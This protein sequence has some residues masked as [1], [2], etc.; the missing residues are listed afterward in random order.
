[1]L[2][3]SF[4]NFFL[5]SNFWA[6]F[7]TNLSIFYLFMDLYIICIF[8]GSVFFCVK[9]NWNIHSYIC[10]N[11]VPFFANINNATLNTFIYFFPFPLF[12]W[13][14]N[15]SFGLDGNL[16][17]VTQQVKGSAPNLTQVWFPNSCPQHL[18]FSQWPFVLLV[19]CIFF[20]SP[21]PSIFPLLLIPSTWTLWTGPV[22][23]ESLEDNEI[24]FRGK[25]V[26]WSKVYGWDSVKGKCWGKMGP[27][28]LCIWDNVAGFLRF[29]APST[30]FFPSFF[31]FHLLVLN[32]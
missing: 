30:V 8:K 7:T 14:T 26:W 24:A 11:C 9:H 16:S 13:K 21:L 6:L 10:E 22:K 4:C 19:L 25:L 29:S 31:P 17:I 27:F 15:L 2:S 23:S 18:C 12:L 20:L 32:I 3:T 1:M 5:L 28:I